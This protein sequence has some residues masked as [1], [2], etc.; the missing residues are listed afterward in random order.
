MLCTYSTSVAHVA[1]FVGSPLGNHDDGLEGDMC[2]R[3][4]ARAPASAVRDAFCSPKF[5]DTVRWHQMRS[6]YVV[7]G[8]LTLA[9]VGLVAAL[10]LAACGS[11]N[12]PSASGS[13]PGAGGSSHAVVAKPVIALSNSFIGNSWRKQMVT[14]FT[15][16][17]AAA[18]S[19]GEISDFVVT[20]ADGTV[21]QQIS[22]ING[23]ILKKV[24]A[25][26][27]DAAS[28][29][30]LNGVITKATQAGIAVVTFDGTATSPDSYNLNYDFTGMGQ[31]MVNVVAAGIGDTGNILVV[32]GVTGTVIDQQTYDGVTQELV[33]HPGL[34]VAGTVYGNWDDATAQSAVARL[35]PTLPK[36]DGVIVNGGG[37]GVAQAFA[38]ANLP[39]PLIYFGNRGYELKWWAEQL[40]KGAYPSE[41]SSTTPAVSTAAFWLAVNVVNGATV[42]HDLKMDLLTITSQDLPNYKDVAVDAVATTT[43][44]DAWVKAHL[45]NQ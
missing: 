25:I 17:A 18:K 38:A 20:N 33:K 5:H 24:N 36:I 15:D 19:S 40:A 29:T 22:Q 31:R 6:R 34:K 45:L 21:E 23:L 2:K 11:S 3:M 10:T 8:R 43:Y 14:A 16:A 30:A 7:R 9:V 37:Y 27:I 12:S 1:Q 13:S 42:K 35:L 28:P 32:R 26:L 39:T 44:D 41:S 4:T